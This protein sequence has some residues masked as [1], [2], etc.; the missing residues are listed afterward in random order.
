M[1]NIP[2]V[3]NSGWKE[4]ASPPSSFLETSLIPTQP[5]RSGGQCSPRSWVPKNVL[6]FASTE[7]SFLCLSFGMGKGTDSSVTSFILDQN[8]K[9]LGMLGSLA[10]KQGPL[11]APK[12]LPVPRRQVMERERSKGAASGTA[13]RCRCRGAATSPCRPLPSVPTPRTG[14]F[15]ENLILN[16]S[17][18]FFPKC[19]QPSR[20][21]K[22]FFLPRAWWTWP[23]GK[24]N[25]VFKKGLDS[26]SGL[27]AEVGNS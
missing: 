9:L 6:F 24:V 5:L 13:G 16:I 21:L 11:C 20:V 1:I 14:G 15:A 23:R 17:S 22:G 19:F 25:S 7:V 10:E 27:V 2:G 8:R 12:H 3:L 4:R 18:F 26:V